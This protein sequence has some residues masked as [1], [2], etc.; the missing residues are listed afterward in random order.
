[1]FH[2][3]IGRSAQ[4]Q[5]DIVC[6]RQN[7]IIVPV[8][9]SKDG[10]SG[11]VLCEI[12]CTVKDI[13]IVIDEDTSVIIRSGGN[14]VRLQDFFRKNA[15]IHPQSLCIEHDTIERNILQISENLPVRNHK[16]SI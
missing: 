15:C 10:S 8:N 12:P 3:K 11:L 9:R 6:R 5:A 1:M 2:E 13:V 7:D 4:S 14:R 16:A